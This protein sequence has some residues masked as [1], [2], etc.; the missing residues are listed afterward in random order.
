MDGQVRHYELLEKLQQLVKSLDF[1]TQ[2]RLPY[3]LLANLAST[4][5]DSAIFT[6]V[7]DL[8]EIQ[9]LTE[10]NLYTQRQKI[11]EEHK[12]LIKNLKKKHEDD[13]RTCKR[14]NLAILQKEHEKQLIELEKRLK[15]E[16]TQFDNKILTQI[17]QKV[18]VQQATLKS[19]GVPGFFVTND[20][21]EIKLQMTLLHL[22]KLVRTSE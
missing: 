7:D 21:Q 15:T 16:L 20:D 13:L 11:L 10:K 2:Q 1:K 22:I 14:H 4:L 8:E 3:D 17:D 18:V 6:I 5:R 19:A 9:H 12:T